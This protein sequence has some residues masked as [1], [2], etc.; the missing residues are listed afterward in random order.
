MGS[1]AMKVAGIFGI[2]LL[3]LALDGSNQASREPVTVT[4][5][6]VEYDTPDLLPVLSQDLQGFRLSG[7]LVLMALS[8]NSP[9]GGSCSKRAPPPPTCTALT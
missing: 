3:S 5:L 1:R 6:D 4:F 7:F 9:C 8:I 2:L